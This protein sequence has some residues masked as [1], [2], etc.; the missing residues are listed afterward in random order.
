[1]SRTYK[2]DEMLYDPDSYETRKLTREID[3]L[4][5]EIGRIRIKSFE[6]TP[7]FAQSTP[8]NQTTRPRQSDS[9]IATARTPNPDF[10]TGSNILQSTNIGIGSKSKVIPHIPASVKLTPEM[11]TYSDSVLET[12]FVT[13]RDRQ[14]LYLAVSL[15]GQ[16]QG[17]LGNLPT[18]KRQNFKELVRSVEERFLPANQTELYRTQLRERRQKAS[19]SLP[20]LGQDIRRLANLSYPTAPNDVRETLAKEQFF[21]G[22]MSVDMRLRIKQAKPAALNDAVRHAV[23]L[24]AFNEAEIKREEGNGYL[25]ATNR[26]ADTSD[27]TVELLKNMQTA[28]SDLQQ[29]VKALQQTQGKGWFPFKGNSQ[30]QN[31]KKRGCFNCGKFGHFKKDC[32]E[33][34]IQ[35]AHSTTPQGPEVPHEKQNGTIGVNKLANE[36]CMFIETKVNGT[37]AKMLIDTGITVSL[38]SKKLFD[39]MHSHVLSPMDRDILTTNG[40]PLILFG[41]TI[42]D[43]EINGSVYSNIAV[44]ADLNADGILGIDFQRSHNCVINITKGSIWVNGRET[45]LHFEDQIGCYRV[46]VATTV[47]LPPTSEVLVSRTI[48][49]P[50]L[51][52]HENNI[53]DTNKGLLDRK[54]VTNQEKN[55]LTCY[56]CNKRFKKTA[57][58]RRHMTRCHQRNGAEIVELTKE[59]DVPSKEKDDESDESEVSYNGSESPSDSGKK[60]SKLG[61]LKNLTEHRE[62]TNVE[63]FIKVCLKRRSTRRPRRPVNVVASGKE[64]SLEV[65]KFIET[66]SRYIENNRD[67]TNKATSQGTGNLFDEINSK[68]GTVASEIEHLQMERT[69]FENRQE[70]TKEK[71]DTLE[72]EKCRTKNRSKVVR[73][74]DKLYVN[75]ELV[76]VANDEAP[77][78]EPRQTTTGTRPK[79]RSRVSST[80]DREGQS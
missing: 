65:L 22:L 37:K 54:L 61:E 48:R 76:S 19:E 79:K 20:E 51:P 7:D 73:N 45:R 28:L 9:G 31:R 24:E 36:A 71:I 35:G 46:Y 75:D 29:E 68:T 43:I 32:P 41:K 67:C 40:S 16:A 25:R 15:R 27:K 80:P 3:R 5:R 38:I 63:T 8:I 10:G 12:N 72:K 53:V 69:G 50:V 1:M 23:E 17:V 70:N 78:E 62:D 11:R 14:G 52:I 64:K 49:E 60:M 2:E 55:R 59:Q 77:R 39:S 42:L 44:V 26:E 47:K 30:F 58:H 13:E 4:N 57:Y 74:R 18:D 21:D 6:N 33:S 34:S 66:V 56:Q